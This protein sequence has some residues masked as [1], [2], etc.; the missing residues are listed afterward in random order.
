MSGLRRWIV[1]DRSHAQATYLAARQRE[2]LELSIACVRTLPVV[3]RHHPHARL[4]RLRAQSTDWLVARLRARHA[5]R[6]LDLGCGTG[7]LAARLARDLGAGVCAV[8]VHLADLELAQSAFADVP[9]LRFCQADVFAPD[10]DELVPDGGFDA[11]VMAG[12][13]PYFPDLPRLFARLFE[14]LAE[15]GEILL[16][17]SPFWPQRKLAAA[18]ARSQRHYAALGVPDAVQAFH[19]HGLAELDGLAACFHYRPEAWR[20]RLA[21]VLLRRP[22][23]PFPRISVPRPATLRS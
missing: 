16:V 7:W 14:L 6:V 20:A 23:S 18:R 15:P 21:R 17:D 8:D 11:V 3:D 13:A 19:H 5:R 1:P 4:W 9:G 10:F 12:V 2:G 22:L